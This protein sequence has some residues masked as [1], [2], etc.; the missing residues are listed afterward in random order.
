MENALR[1]V[2][3]NNDFVKRGATQAWNRACRSIRLSTDPVLWVEI[4]PFAVRAAQPVIDRKVVTVQ[5]GVDA[6]TRIVSR[7]TTPKC[8]SLPSEINLESPRRGQL[9]LIMP[10]MLD[11]DYLDE[12]L[13]N[14][15]DKQLQQDY[16]DFR[17]F[18]TGPHGSSLLVE[19]DVAVDT[20]SKATVCL[21]A[22]P[23]ID[24]VSRTLVLRDVAVYT[25]SGNKCVSV[26]GGGAAEAL[27]GMALNIGPQI[28]AFRQKANKAFRGLSNQHFK[29]GGNL[30]EVRPT[31]VDVGPEQLR[32]VVEGSARDVSIR[33]P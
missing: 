6:Y 31:R 23:Q 24:A 13:K 19:A 8:G 12:L 29:I 18:R 20:S 16:L 30:T 11:Y 5:V 2:V 33:I 32:L 15:V 17:E 14:V 22:K 9:N 28:D 21:L 1:D 7:R 3:R 27:E 10:V 26:G 4:K 25:E